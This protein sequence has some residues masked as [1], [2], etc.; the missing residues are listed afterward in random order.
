[1][2]AQKDPIEIDPVELQKDLHDRMQRYLL[3]AL[4]I[5]RRFPKL[6]A[7]ASA[8]LSRNNTLVRGPY[9]EALPD[10]PKTK[11]IKD[12]V[13]A[14]ML[15][16][17]FR[18]MDPKV[19]NRPLHQ[20]QAEAIQAVVQKNENIVVAT[21]TG[22]GKTECFLFPLI[23]SLLKANIK[24]RP[25]IRAILV[26][27]LNALAND[28][29]Y[30]R[31]VPL[32]AKELGEHGITVG[33]YTGQTT[34]NKQRSYFQNEYLA[35]P[36][37]KDLFGDEIPDNWLLSRDEMLD[38]PPHV[39]VTNYA[40]LEHLLLLPKNAPLFQNADLQFLVLDELHTYA[41]AQASEVSL[42]LRKLRNRY[43][44]ENTLRCIGT[45]ASLGDS[46]QAQKDVI[47]FATRLFGFPFSQ[48]ITAKRESHYLLETEAAKTRL[49]PEQWLELHQILQSVRHLQDEQERITQ[50]NDRTMDANIELLVEKEGESL[51][52]LLCT[53]L[54]SDESVREVSDIL[55]KEGLQSVANLAQRVFPQGLELAERALAGLVAIGAYARESSSSFPLLPA[56]YHLFTRGIEEATIELAHSDHHEENAVNLRFR[57]EFKDPET[58]KSRFRLMTCRKCGELYFEA[59]EKGQHI[60]PEHGGPGWKRSVFWLKPKDSY[61]IPADSTEDQ[62]DDKDAPTPVWIHL[63]SGETK[64]ELNDKD[65]PAQWFETNRAKMVDPS[66]E[67]VDANPG[68]RPVVTEC[69]S[70]GSRDR[71]EII[72]AFHP[73]DQALSGT[74]CEVLYS[75][76]PTTSDEAKRHRQ[77]GR[78]RNLLVFSD[79]RQDA[80]FFAPNFQRSHEDLLTRRAIVRALKENGKAKLLGL[81][82][83]LCH[84]NYLLK[85]GLTNREGK[86]AAPVD[87]A[88]II[89]GKL[90]SEFCSPGG[91]RVSLEDL[92]LVVVEYNMVD[93]E[94]IAERAGIPAH[95]GKN[96]VRWIIDSIRLKRAIS[97]PPEIREDDDFVWGSYAQ[98]DRRYTLETKDNDARF[99]LLGFRPSG[100]PYLSGYV[101]VLRD[102]LKI[103]NWEQILRKVW[104]ILIDDYDGSAV[105]RTD[106]E[107]T[108]LRVLDHRYLSI[109]L[110]SEDE[111][112]YRCDKCSRISHYSV[113]GICT[114]WRCNGHA[115]KV[116][117][118]DWDAE[119]QRNHY[120][121]LYSVLSDMPSIIAREHTAAIAT[122]VRETIESDFKSG[123]INML[124]SSTTMEMGIDLGDLEGVFLRNAPPDISNYQQRAGRAG[125]RAQAAPVSITYSRNRRYDQDVFEHTEEFLR[126]EPRTPHVHLGNSRLFQRHQFSI[127]ISHYLADLHLNDAGIQIG[128]LFGLPRFTIGG[129]TL[130]PQGGMPPSFTEADEM[131]FLERITQ[132]LSSSTSEAARLLADDLL[133]SLLPSLTEKEQLTLKQ[134]NANLA[135]TFLAEIEKLAKTFGFR[136]RHYLDKSK[137][138]HD[139]GQMGGD[140]MRNRAYRWS[141][142]P[143]VTFLS[144]QGIIPTYSFPVDSID[145]EVLQGELFNPSGYRTIQ[146]R[147]PRNFRIC[148]RCR[149]HRQWTN[150]DVV[151]HLA[152]PARVHASLLL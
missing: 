88:T 7:Q 128:Q 31:I 118:D 84:A 87:L 131:A 66:N 141:N 142:L 83:D 72:T 27:P 151:C 52:Q 127:L 121:Y 116:P 47:E 106:P 33:R 75:H 36:M 143:I 71:S 39:L 129:G 44:P 2:P 40:M 4:P 9:L 18:D 34:Q 68:A 91:S 98:D 117:K 30:S 105:L 123:E 77:P 17:G 38:T 152:T 120:F 51:S 74:I 113:G 16:E 140:K 70:C 147:T 42:L 150:L 54:A 28:Q 89:R 15:H 85:G 56:R 125:R 99:R 1:M 50:W 65:E 104:E 3:T 149:G 144:K 109:R 62:A 67:D 24:G 29:L 22:S 53:T 135:N 148:T 86:R 95:L 6:R 48:V 112:V 43:A 61:V 49:A 57:R 25:G 97:M 103:D 80:A 111:S 110:R 124:S 119:I 37:I 139:A 133:T 32:L 41:G 55:S 146:R 69:Q 132:W 63:H 96:I 137:E 14:G 35:N 102:K 93:L 13:D 94:D 130:S 10:Y 134:Q 107:G 46:P 78:G 12:L 145:L 58:D 23:D 82:D 5:H 114:Q 79:N 100:T 138:L 126:K 11:S 90:F 92:G 115:K 8:E 81:A 60:I 136:F 108:Q 59:F 101:E 26:Y 45:S 73:G 20:H 64:P 19:F 122:H 21:G 76:L